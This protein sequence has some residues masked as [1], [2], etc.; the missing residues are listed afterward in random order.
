M[1]TVFGALPMGEQ[2]VANLEKLIRIVRNCLESVRYELTD[3]V[4]D[5][6]D[7]ITAQE[8]KGEAALDAFSQTSV[9]I[10]TVHAAKGL[11]FL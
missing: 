1:L 3:L 2:K 5:L 9:N 10:M 8:R 4:S 7:S 11:N 6:Y